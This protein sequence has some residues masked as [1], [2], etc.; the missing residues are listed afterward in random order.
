MSAARKKQAASQRSSRRPSTA[1]GRDR[2]RVQSSSP[3]K[4]AKKP[5]AASAKTPAQRG[6]SERPSTPRKSTSADPNQERLQKVLAAAGFGSRRDCE[7]LIIEGRVEVDGVVVDELG[8]KVDRNSQKIFVDGERIKVAKRE[9]Y[10]IN[11]PTGVISTNWD[12]SGRMRVIDLIP[13]GQRVFTVGRL[14]KSSEGLMIVT[15]DGELAQR[16][17]HPSFGVEKIY[18]V[19]VAGHPSREEL[20]Q[21]LDG[22]RLADGWAKAKRIRVRRKIKNTA[23]LEMILD[24]GRNREIRRL[25]A[26]IGHKVIRLKR[27]A[28]GTLRLGEMAPGD[29]RSLSRD[30][31]R[32][33]RRLTSGSPKS[34][35]SSGSNSATRKFASRS[36]AS[37][38]RSSST[39]KSDGASAEAR[40]GK[41]RSGKSAVPGKRSAKSSQRPA[42]GAAASS[43]GRRSP[44]KKKAPR[45]GS[46]AGGPKRRPTKRTR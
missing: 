46:S 35:K 36:T 6:K 20:Q 27:V 26:R 38:N 4:K 5:K 30:E 25:L 7:S 41:R 33:L 19:T 32:E 17:T 15:N 21:L 8:S 11:K 34:K 1:S 3:K 31:V 22:V 37:S 43:S 23:V 40:V 39:R 9:Y 42:R 45:R 13:T 2:A 12:P 10:L 29:C 14:D 18:E 16:L 28:L 44:G 24:E